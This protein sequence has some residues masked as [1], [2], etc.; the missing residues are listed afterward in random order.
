MRWMLK[1][2]VSFLYLWIAAPAGLLTL[3]LAANLEYIARADGVSYRAALEK[4]DTL[5][6]IGEKRNFED[7]EKTMRE[8]GSFCITWTEADVKNARTELSSINAL[9]ETARQARASEMDKIFSD[10]SLIFGYDEVIEERISMAE[11]SRVLIVT[12]EPNI[13]SEVCVTPEKFQDEI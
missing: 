2:V 5:M 1:K 6:Y 10:S 4:H 12:M 7:V 8:D 13:E 3:V 9:I 11:T